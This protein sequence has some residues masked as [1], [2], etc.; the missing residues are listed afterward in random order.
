MPRFRPWRLPAQAAIL[1]L[2]IG[3]VQLAGSLLFYQSIDRQTLREDH[4]RRIAELL[5]VSER[6]HA[7]DPRQVV[8]VMSTRHL[9][10]EVAL[11]PRVTHATTARPLGSIA[12]EVVR[13]EPGLAGRELHLAYS[14]GPAGR[15][16]LVGSM[17]LADGSWLNFRSSDIGSMWPVATRAMVL[18]LLTALACLAVGLAALGFLTRP[19][20]RLTRAADAIGHGQRVEIDEQGSADLRDLAHAMNVMQERIA[21]LVEDQARS[22]EA[23]SHDLRTPL[24]R[25]RVAADLVE[26]RELAE[27]M[28][29]SIDEMEGLIGS[30]QGYLR[31]QHIASDP[32][33]ADLR[34]LVDAVAAQHGDR[35]QVT[36]PGH[37]VVETYVEPVRL[38]LGALVDN[39]VRFGGAA[40]VTIAH[41]PEGWTVAV[42]DPGIGIPPRHFADV[43][44][45][46]FRVDEARSRDVPGF[47]LG[48]PTAHRLMMRFGGELSFEARP[49]GGFVARIRV[50]EAAEG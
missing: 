7:I 21:R 9:E 49:Q 33:R 40:Q 20:R 37:A 36:G 10:A 29:A 18:T 35:V 4:A 24:S 26:D 41:A 34:A 50:P 15:R 47:G 28:G 11:R 8:E 19:L 25:Q 3:L 12:K 32:S 45:P 46:F 27:I 6:I 42:A 17:R 13:W 38:A 1:L 48:I 39:A 31:A 43:L 30:L 23:I 16:D 2:L 5:V 44:T 22:F 14:G